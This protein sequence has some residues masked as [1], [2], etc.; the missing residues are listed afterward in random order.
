M[1]SQTTVMKWSGALAPTSPE[2]DL[3]L[4]LIRANFRSSQ[5][6]DFGSG[7]REPG[8]TRCAWPL[9]KSKVTTF[10]VDGHT[11]NAVHERR[12]AVHAVSRAMLHSIDD[13]AQ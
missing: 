11:A 2:G 5:H 4:A 7:Q 9:P 3:R 6:P 13:V 12:E 10:V 8:Q 1:Q